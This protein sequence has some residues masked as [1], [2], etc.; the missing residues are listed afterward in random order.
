MNKEIYRHL[1]KRDLC[2][3]LD[4]THQTLS[5]TD[6]DAFKKNVLDLRDIFPFESSVCAYGNIETALSQKVPQIN[7][8]DISYPK[9]YL[10]LY[11]E[12]QYHK[13]DA[14]IFEFLANLKPVNWNKLE[15][16][17]G[18]YYPASVTAVDFGMKDGWTYGVLDIDSMNCSTFFF[19][20]PSF[21]DGHIRTEKILEYIIP[22]LSEAYKK[23][24]NKDFSPDV[25]LTPREIEVINWVKE[26]KSSWEISVILH[27]SKRAV[28]FHV[29]NIKRKLSA[30]SRT[31]A[32]A[33]ALHKEIIKF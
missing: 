23:L 9:G 24:I 16:G 26:G 5:C 12:K 25:R 7:L 33:I 18:F 28:D 27:C 2:E 31:Q 10:D 17:N 13:T 11:F 6:H 14:V 20:N 22:F 32:V 15:C 19:G 21:V 8:L 29:T 1:S 4:L 30:V 3:I